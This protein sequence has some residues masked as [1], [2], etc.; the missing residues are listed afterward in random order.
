MKKIVLNYMCS[1]GIL[2]CTLTPSFSQVPGN[3]TLQK[4]NRPQNLPG[5]SGSKLSA[6][7]NQLITLSRSG[8]VTTLG[9]TPPGSA[10]NS[11]DKIVQ[12]FDGKVLIDATVAGD[13]AQAKS[14]LQKA[15]ARITGSYGR[16]ISAL[17]PL[18]SLSS[19]EK[20]TQI[21]FVRPAYKPRHQS[22]LEAVAPEGST[23]LGPAPTT[24]VYSQGD[25]AQGSYLARKKFKADG[26]GVKVGILSDSY[27]NRG[28]AEKGVM[29]GELPG[30]QNPDHHKKPVK[31]LVDLDS[32][33]IDEGRAMAE[34]VHDVAPG[35]EIAFNTAYLGQ[36][37]F[38]QG[39]VDLA[40][41]GCKVIT[42]DIFY[43]AEP[44]FQDGIIAQAVDYV[45]KKGV[46]YFSSAGNGSARSYESSYKA[47][48]Y[49]PV[50][51]SFGTAH[52]FAAPGAKPIY[53]QPIQVPS[54][55]YFTVGFQWDDPSFSAGGTGA[56]TDMDIYVFDILGNTVAYGY[57]A[58]TATGEPVELTS[59]YNGT[60]SNTFFISLV[61]YSGPNPTR[62]KY[63]MFDDGAFFTDVPI[64][65]QFAPTI[66]GHA[67][68]QGAIA[69]AAA[70]YKATPA[71]GTQVPWVEPFSSL[72][73]TR[74]Y[75][76]KGGNRISAQIRLKPEIT[77][78]DGGNT[79]FFYADEAADT[80]NF[81]NFSGTSASAPHAAAV[82]A[83]M[84]EAQKL[85]TL[86]PAQIRGILSSKTYDMDNRYTAGFDKGFDYNTG[87]G[88]IRAEQA[89][90]EVKFPNLYIK[91]LELVSLCSDDPAKSRNWKIV[92]P[93]P[94]EVKAH[95]FLTGFGQDSKTVVSAGETFF[96]TTTGY[97]RNKPVP[98]VVILDW[99]DNFGFTRFDIASATTNTCQQDV[100]GTQTLST[101]DEVAILRNE[102]DV[103]PEIAEV[104]PNPSH[105]QFKLYLSLNAPGKAEL[106]L[107]GDD[108]K[109][110]FRNTVP[111][112]GIYDIDASK[113]Q[114]GLYLMKIRQGSFTKTLKLVKQ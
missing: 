4:A 70:W 51:A 47:T 42:D 64:P 12:I 2:L 6:E 53:Y 109:L 34:I 33:G 48:T 61:K 108:G 14:E 7:L 94:F 69:T 29:N 101:G 104:F 78:P 71:Y 72:G 36:G 65:G 8:D 76:D 90:G 97:F 54:G 45:V 10:R 92:N 11:L 82:A 26:K 44:Y 27:N 24:T 93:N 103:K 67:N 62:V 99:E 32:G 77:A 35:A 23:L 95:W 68:S 15:G 28:G 114:P 79:S 107:Y 31:V 66:V 88:L 16:V 111:G 81:P 112:S 102:K 17:I 91:N 75:F 110:L 63:I 38:A 41:A 89:V 52:N 73:G 57:D 80:D 37:A 43:L 21:K 49:E 83:L 86:T 20:A 30:L 18:G 40:G 85:N 113:Y 50:G 5:K 1:A 100:A 56:E 59:F 84:I 39:I 3:P 9:K 58:N 19:L 96:T 22:R 87:T 55:S 98:N 25:T 13:Q 46:T 106:A 60:T 105:A 74:I